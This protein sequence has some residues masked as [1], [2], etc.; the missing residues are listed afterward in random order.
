MVEIEYPKNPAGE[1]KEVHVFVDFD[2]TMAH[3]D[4][5]E[6]QGNN[7][8]KPIKPMIEKIKGW[9]KKKYKISVF[10]ARLTHG[11]VESEKQI[12]LI[13]QFLRENGLPDTLPIT[14]MKMHYM[15]HQICDRAFHVV[16]NTGHIEGNTG[17]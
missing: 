3:Y 12:G 13:Q 5:W 11:A 14:C 2:G 15:T 8:G 1:H 4:S 6:Q 16:K 9:L 10:T 7:V 17:L